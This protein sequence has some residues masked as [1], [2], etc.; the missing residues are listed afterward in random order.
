MNFVNY[1]GRTLDMS[2]HTA[3]QVYELKSH[4]KRTGK[5]PTDV[6]TGME[7]LFVAPSYQNGRQIAVAHGRLPSDTGVVEL[8]NEYLFDNDLMV[9]RVDDSFQKSESYDPP[10]YCLN[11]HCG[12]SLGQSRTHYLGNI[13]LRDKE[14]PTMNYECILRA[15]DFS[16]L[17]DNGCDVK[18]EYRLPI[19]SQGNRYRIIDNAV[20]DN[21][22]DV[23]VAIEFQCSPI[24]AEALEQRINDY[25]AA[26]IHQ[27]WILGG[28]CQDNSAMKDVLNLHGINQFSWEFDARYV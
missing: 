4:A 18:G 19:P 27:V 16:F 17:L 21:N 9:Q 11:L 25:I 28:K 24:S 23:Q 12:K 10:K 22:G 5:R 26:E 20:L 7:V 13:V 6:I 8:Q 14:Q 15:I 3:Q 2:T 1:D